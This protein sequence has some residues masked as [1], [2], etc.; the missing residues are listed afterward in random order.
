[1][2]KICNSNSPNALIIRNYKGMEH[3]SDVFLNNLL[4]QYDLR[5]DISQQPNLMIF[6]VGDSY[7]ATGLDFTEPANNSFIDLPELREINPFDINQWVVENR[8]S[9]Q[10]MAN[11][12]TKKLGQVL[13]RWGTPH[14]VLREICKQL[15]VNGGIT[16]INGLWKIP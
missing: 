1:L 3:V 12:C 8:Q 4:Q 6:W 5:T 15:G 14:V 10:R 16:E 9:Y 7:P 2:K 13:P 11:V